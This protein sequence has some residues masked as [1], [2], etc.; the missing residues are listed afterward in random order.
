MQLYVFSRKEKDYVGFQEVILSLE[1]IKYL[2]HLRETLLNF[3]IEFS[4]NYFK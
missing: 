1:R 4:M 2:I 3:S